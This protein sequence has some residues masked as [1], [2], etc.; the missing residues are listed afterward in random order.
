MLTGGVEISENDTA[1]ALGL[2]RK[3]TACI[4]ESEV[5]ER[6]ERLRGDVELAEIRLIKKALKECGGN[7]TETARRLGISRTTLWRKMQD[8][9]IDAFQ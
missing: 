7:K 2:D 8:E 9:D 6:E 5:P 4:P 3:Q 1:R